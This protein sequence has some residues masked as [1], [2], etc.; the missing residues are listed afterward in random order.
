[1]FKSLLIANRGEIACRV[2]QSAQRLGCRTIAVYSKADASA[3]HTQIAEEAVFAG[4]SPVE[5]SYLNAERI[6]EIAE[7]RG[8]DAI[9]PGYGFLSEN[10]RFA[11][12]CAE[13]GLAFIGP[14]PEAIRQMGAKNVAKT[15][16]SDAGI[17][18]L[19]GYHGTSHDDQ[20]LREQADRIGYPILVKAVAGG[21][22]KGMRQVDDGEHLLEALDACRREAESAFGNDALLLEKYLHDPRHVEVQIFGD[23]MGDV[24]HLFDR[25]CSIQRRHQKIVEEAPARGLSSELAARMRAS[26]VDAGKAIGYVGAGTVEFLVSEDRYYFMEM[27]TRLQVEHPV[28]EMITGIDLVE[29]QLRVAAGQPLPEKQESIEVRGHAVEARLYAEDVDRQ[30][31]PTG[32]QIA[33]LKFPRNQPGIRVD[34]GVQTGDEVGVFYD[35]M[36]AK[37]VS[38]GADPETALMRL[39]EALRNTVIAGV[40]TNLSL[41]IAIVDHP[42]LTKRPPNTGYLRHHPGLIESPDRTVSA[43]ALMTV[44]LYLHQ[45]AVADATARANQSADAFSPWWQR[46]GWQ[47]NAASEIIFEFRHDEHR[48]RIRGQVSGQDLLLDVD[49]QRDL[50]RMKSGGDAH[51]TVTTGRS[52]FDAIVVHYES[53]VLVA[54]GGAQWIFDLANRTDHTPAEMRNESVIRSPMPGKIIKLLVATG[55]QLDIGQPVV[56]IEAMKMEHTVNAQRHGVVDHVAITEGQI[57][58]ENQEIISLGSASSE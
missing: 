28:T 15:I 21:G 36:I 26:A 14:S 12:A 30:F 34:T 3:L 7:A 39:S 24:V 54:V 41:L 13:R 48:Y 37:I 27:N 38:H 19:P 50:A 6:L 4:P 18:I 23:Q 45:E 47:A 40:K 2:I 9:H 44:C 16:M 33:F 31:L 35:P 51:F 22:G 52:R 42:A 20:T 11:T 56:I 58:E 53:H 8:A 49:G 5:Q 1:M 46:D 57:V 43:D 17:P 25:D 10:A 29:W 32:G 55:D